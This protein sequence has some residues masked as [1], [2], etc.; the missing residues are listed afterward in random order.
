M[1]KRSVVHAATAIMVSTAMLV[2]T[3]GWNVSASEGGG[4]N[5]E[6]F[7]IHDE[8]FDDSAWNMSGQIPEATQQETVAPAEPETEAPALVPEVPVTEAPVIV[9]EAPVTEAPVIVSEAPETEAPVIVPEAPETEAPVIVPEASETEAPVIVPETPEAEVSEIISE[10]PVAEEPVS[11]QEEPAEVLEPGTAEE[12][13]LSEDVFENAADF[14]E[15]S[16]ESEQ[17]GDSLPEETETLVEESTFESAVVFGEIAVEKVNLIGCADQAATVYGSPGMSSLTIDT[18]NPGQ[19]VYIYEIA[20]NTGENSIWYGILYAGG[21]SSCAGYVST[22]CILV[23]DRDLF[24]LNAG[25]DLASFPQSYRIYLEALQKKHPKW[26]FQAVPVGDSFDEAIRQEQLVPGHSLVTMDFPEYWRSVL[27]KG[28]DAAGQIYDYNPAT[29]VWYEWEPGWAAASETALR[30]CM[31]PRNFLNE[32]DIFMFE[33]LKYEKYQTLAAVEATLQGTFMDSVN[34]PGESFTYAWLFWW[35]GEKFDINPIALASRVK[36]EQGLGKSDLIS[37]QYSGYKGLYNYFNM[38]AYGHTQAEIIQRGLEEAKKGSTILLPDGTNYKG[39]W[40]TPAKAIIGGALNFAAYYILKGQD[41]LYEQKYDI[42]ETGGKYQHQYMTNITAPLTEGRMMKKGYAEAG[43]YDSAIV[44]MI[45]VYLDMP[46][47]NSKHPEQFSAVYSGM[48]YSLVF[49]G[50]YYLEHNPNLQKEFGT[51]YRKALA[52]FVNS[53]IEKGDQANAEFNVTYYY[54][55]YPDLQK[56]FGKDNAALVN[57]YLTYGYKEKRVASRLLQSVAE[58]KEKA[59]EEA[60]AKAAAEKA[61]KEAAE[62]A[63]KEKA[64]KEAAAKAA[65]EKAAKE[66]AEKAAKEKAAK[67]AAEKAAKEKAAKEAAEKAAKEKAA[68]EAAEKAAAEKAAKEAAEKAALEVKKAVYGGVDYGRVFN[69]VYYLNKYPDLKKAFGTDEK[70]ALEHFIQFGIVEGRQAC[71]SFSVLEYKENYEDL[72]KAFGNDSR[73]YVQ[74]YLSHGYGE[75]RSGIK[76]SAAGTSSSSASKSGTSAGQSS[77]TTSSGS[78]TTSSASAE[79]T[80][81]GTSSTGVN[82]IYNGTDYSKV[83]DPVYYLNKYP[84]LKAAFG[85]DAKAALQHFVMHGISEGRQA[86]AAFSLSVYYSSNADLRAAFGRNN[87]MLVNHYLTY[88][89]KEGRVTH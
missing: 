20:R 70:K 29:G 37:G 67:E 17:T 11:E 8:D 31:D 13:P 66:A 47:E 58:A 52:Y 59:A 25:S 60:A 48:D 42:D 50:A 53:G 72:R 30:Y 84:D 82:W 62:K 5:L 14:E 9:P 28:T 86:S 64:A 22:D 10:A 44:F 4:E 73:M 38:G 87:A 51:D 63:A 41:T 3:F 75:K 2:Q 32:E 33:S 23:T 19:T 83:F 78:S 21:E 7:E 40:N 54:E 77:Q 12:E 61:A 34:V 69:A 57:H 71:A 16:D 36:Q 80:G 24:R 55:N 6:I 89:C 81:T 79:K 35:I 68:K 65:A 27:N 56:A 74:H 76:L 46:S 1:K 39:A 43:I 26:V 15:E 18:I 49:D 88:G 85:N 45:P